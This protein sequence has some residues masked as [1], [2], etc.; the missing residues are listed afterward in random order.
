[1]TVPGVAIR[2]ID[3]NLK[4]AGDVVRSLQEV[5]DRIREQD[6]QQEKEAAQAPPQAQFNLSGAATDAAARTVQF[7]NVVNISAGVAQARVLG[8]QPP[9]ANT[10][11]IRVGDQTIGLLKSPGRPSFNVVV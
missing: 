1:V 8:E 9:P 11:N 3:R 2:T 6:A 10:L 4:Q 7:V 5:R